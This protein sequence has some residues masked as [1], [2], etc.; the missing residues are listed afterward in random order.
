MRHHGLHDVERV[1][2]RALLTSNASTKSE[3]NRFLLAKVSPKRD[4]ATGVAASC[5][6]RVVL[7]EGG[8]ASTDDGATCV[9]GNAGGSISGSLFAALLGASKYEIWT[10]VHGVFTCDPRYVPDARLIGRMDY[11]QAI[12]MGGKTLHPQCIG[13]AQWANVPME[14][15]NLNDPEGERTMIEAINEDF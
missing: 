6:C 13:P 7:T 14:V 11:H 2:A 8:I 10:D 5:G 9:L 4:V 15:R 1:D 3:E 12:A